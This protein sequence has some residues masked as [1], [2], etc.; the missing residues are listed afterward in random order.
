VAILNVGK[1]KLMDTINKLTIFL[2]GSLYLDG[3]FKLKVHVYD[4]EKPS[5]KTITLVDGNRKVRKNRTDIDI[6]LSEHR[7]DTFESISFYCFCEDDKVEEMTEELK[8]A[9]IS[10]FKDLERIYK[11]AKDAISSPLKLTTSV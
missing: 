7:N 6:V 4:V 2:L 11:S 3:E 1:I 8:K 9:A 5:P 10:K